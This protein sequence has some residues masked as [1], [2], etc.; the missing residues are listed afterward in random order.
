MHVAGYVKQE[1]LQK[2]N[3]IHVQEEGLRNEDSDHLH[4]QEHD[5]SRTNVCIHLEG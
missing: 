3:C 4:K 1:A 5:M 2:Q